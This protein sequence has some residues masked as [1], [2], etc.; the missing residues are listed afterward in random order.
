MT[1]ADYIGGLTVPQGPGVG[2]LF[3]VLPWEKKFLKGFE[4]TS[5]DVSMTL[6]R[7]NGKSGLVAGIACAVVD[8]S[9]PLHGPKHEVVVVAS[10]F[11]QG[12]IIYEDCQSILRDK[13][14]LERRAWRVQD[15]VNTAT[16]QHR[17]SGARIRCIGSD[18]R[19]AHGLRPRLV[20]ADEPAQWD[21]AK[22]DRMLAALRTGLGKVP[23]SRLL[24]IGTRPAS[25]EH[26]FRKM[27]KPGGCA[28]SL[29]Y[30][31]GK[32]DPPFHWRTVLK[33]N[34]SLGIMPDLAAR[35][36]EEMADAK[37]DPALLPT[38]ESLRLNKGVSDVGES[39]L[40]SPDVWKSIETAEPDRSGPF[41]LG[42]DLGTSAAMS[43]AAAYFVNTGALDSFA[44]FPEKPALDER[45]RLDG[46]GS[47]YQDMQKR[48]ELLLAG[49]FV[50]DV[51]FLLSECLRRWGRP[52][53]VVSD[54]WREAELRQALG[55]ARFPLAALSLRGQGFK[56][57]AED[58]RQFRRAC[59]SGH[60]RPMRSLLMRS[61]MA[62]AR[63]VSDP[64]GNAKLSKKTEGG[65]RDLARDDA[66][67]AAI[68][69]VSEGIR[70]GAGKGEAVVSP[71]RWRYAGAA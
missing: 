30:A 5:G 11:A 52:L 1:L 12:R 67:A 37:R 31:A 14:G 58:V 26:W 54:R 60:V 18:P 8:P 50:S 27:L 24:A 51:P 68:L 38:F 32:D 43:A 56:D 63:T 53:A 69:A 21:K 16:I 46:V 17:A 40:V 64:S 6:S 66:A 41:V 7:G 2:D 4:A 34:P 48:C 45:G 59:L 25:R 47:L 20:L 39:V 9:G 15:S 33:A 70:R 28:F 35:I 44:V 22:T 29:C 49:E 3:H 65:R 55:D 23:G 13:T 61:A 62:E 71:R 10:S 36:R 42:V 57:G 19:R